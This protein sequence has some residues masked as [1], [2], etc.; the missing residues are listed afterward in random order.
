VHPFHESH[1]LIAARCQFASTS[2]ITV[3]STARAL[4]KDV[5]FCCG[6][7]SG[8]VAKRELACRRPPFDFVGWNTGN[9]P[10]G[11][12]TDFVEVIGKRLDSADFHGNHGTAH[13]F[14]AT[15]SVGFPAHTMAAWKT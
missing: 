8:K 7:V 12:L 1:N 14:V 9:N 4:R 11:A 6:N 5:S 15:L 13:S 2:V 10:H 3:A